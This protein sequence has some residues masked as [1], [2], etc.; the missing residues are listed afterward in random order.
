M[1]RANRVIDNHYAN[2]K[3]A[4]LYDISCGW[5]EDREFYLS[6]AN[7]PNMDILE[8]GC[9]TG[10]ISRAYAQLGHAVVGVDPSS[11]MLDFARQETSSANIDW[12][13]A[14][15]QDYKTT[16][17][18]CVYGDWLKSIFDPLESKEMVYV[19]QHAIA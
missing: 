12:V 1:T 7:E 14:Y 15:A 9:G 5:S 10:L 3:L 19:V 8:L 4:A 13:E 18:F 6:L 11:S 2:K 16:R 17:R